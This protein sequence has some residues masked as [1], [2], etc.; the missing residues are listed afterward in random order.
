MN[1]ALFNILDHLQQMADG[2]GKAIQTDN[3][4]H[5]AGGAQ[6]VHLCIMDLIVGRDACI[7]DKTFGGRGCI[8]DLPFCHDFLMR[9]SVLCRDNECLRKGTFASV[10]YGWNAG[11]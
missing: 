2:A 6:L 1:A 4:K 5:I 10:F 7:T 9:F 8:G 3:D 11:L